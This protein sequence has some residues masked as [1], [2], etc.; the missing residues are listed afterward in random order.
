MEMASFGEDPV[1]APGEVTASG[2][3][4]AV[5]MASAIAA[6]LTWRDGF[7]VDMWA[8]LGLG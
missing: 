8:A 7:A 5:R 4:A 3:H 1:E 2:A 6:T